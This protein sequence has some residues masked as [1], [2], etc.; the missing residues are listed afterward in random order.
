MRFPDT[1]PRWWETDGM[2]GEQDNSVTH[3]FPTA[4]A[5]QEAGRVLGVVMQAGD[6]VALIG[7][8]GAGKTT[9]VQGIA[10]GLDVRGEVVSPTFALMNV[11]E[12]RL[13]LY[14]LDVYRLEDERRLH[15]L[16]YEPESADEGVTLVEWADRVWP[17]WTDDVLRLTISILPQG[18]REIMAEAGGTASER[19]RQD[20]DAALDEVK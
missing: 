11:Y 19:L 5:M 8:L 4:E 3:L 12:G 14:H 10:A 18:G 6:G 2:P 20:W 1:S 7:P 9:L 16:G 17:F 15:A 13:P